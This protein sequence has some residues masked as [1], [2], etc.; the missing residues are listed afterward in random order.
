[1][2]SKTNESEINQ[3]DLWKILNLYKNSEYLK[4]NIL[5]NGNQII[6][7]EYYLINIKWIK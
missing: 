2:E 4:K 1:M 7:E 5:A 3:D 6:S